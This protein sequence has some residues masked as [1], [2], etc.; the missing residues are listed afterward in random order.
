MSGLPEERSRF[1]PRGIGKA[2]SNETGLF[3]EMWAG[4]GKSSIA[5]LKKAFDQA[6]QPVRIRVS[7]HRQHRGFS[8]VDMGQV[9][10]QTKT[11]SYFCDI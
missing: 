4:A 6:R 2:V 1:N 8:V 9:S 11:L 5:P 10:Y 7:N 3:D